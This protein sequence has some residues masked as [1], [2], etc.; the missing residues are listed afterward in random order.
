[1]TNREGQEPIPTFGCR[2]HSTGD[3][4]LRAGRFGYPRA[5]RSRPDSSGPNSAS[6]GIAMKR[7]NRKSA[8]TY[9]S[10][11][12]ACSAVIVGSCMATLFAVVVLAGLLHAAVGGLAN[13][14]FGGLLA[15]LGGAL[16]A[17][18][19]WT[20]YEFWLIL[21]FEWSQAVWLLLALLGWLLTTGPR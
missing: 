21:D 18:C 4:I 7:S 6:G 16:L 8:R 2:S 3:P 14:L 5:M 1:M 12:L 13:A 20:V 11:V 15:G 10:I 19:I 9:R 17:V